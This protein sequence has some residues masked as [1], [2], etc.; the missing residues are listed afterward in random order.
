MRFETGQKLLD[1]TLHPFYRQEEASSSGF[2][3]SCS[4]S[5][6]LSQMCSLQQCFLNVS[7]APSLKTS[8]S[9]KFEFPPT[10]LHLPSIR[11]RNYGPREATVSSLEEIP[12]NALR[13]KCDPQ[14]RG[15]FSLGVDLGFSRTGLALSKGFAFRPLTVIRFPLIRITSKL[16]TQILICLSFLCWFLIWFKSFRLRQNYGQ[17]WFD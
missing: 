11:T 1:S 5:R 16:F 4:V 13:R 15:G 7:I 2:H 14:W 6:F 8:L 10:S 3:F 17:P 9:L 12:P